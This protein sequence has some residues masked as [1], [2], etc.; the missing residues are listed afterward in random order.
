MTEWTQDRIER[1]Y[2][3]AE[4]EEGLTLEYK[5]AA[6]LEKSDRKKLEVSKDVSAMANSAGG[7]LMYGV[8]EYDEDRKRHLPEKRHSCRFCERPVAPVPG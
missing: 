6:A 1:E 7:R 8:K 2:I 4:V 3:K 5:A